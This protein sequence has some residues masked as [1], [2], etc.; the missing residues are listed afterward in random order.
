[1]NMIVF[2]SRKIFSMSNSLYTIKLT[3]DVLSFRNQ[4]FYD[5]VKQECGDII[6]EIMQLQDISS[7]DCLLDLSDIF[8]FLQQDSDELITIK[9]K[10]GIF[11]ND[12]GYVLKTGLVYKAQT[13][14]N[15]LRNL[16]RK[17]S[18]PS[19][20]QKSNKSYGLL[21]PEDI[22]QKFS[23]VRTFTVYSDLINSSKH[24]FTLLNIILNNMFRNLGTD[25]KGFRYEAVVRQ[26]ATALYILGGRNAYE[27]VRMN[28]AGLL[29]SVQVIQSFITASD[30]YLTEGDFNYTGAISYFKSVEATLGF[31]AEDATS[32]VPKISYDTKSNTFVGFSLPL[33]NFGFPIKNSYSTESFNQLEEWYSDIA[34]A[35]L[36]TAYLIQPLSSSINKLSPYLLAAYGTDNTFRSADVISR[37]HR[38]HQECKANGIRII[39]FATDC[40][41]RYLQAMRRSLGFF[42]TFVY[43][44]HP[45]LLWINLPRSWSWFFMQHEQLYICFQDPIHICTKLRNRLLSETTNLLLGNQ[46]INMEPL[47]DLID[48][49][50]KIDH[51]LVR[52]DIDPKDRQN[53]SSAAKISSDN[54]LL[55][56][57]KNTNAFGM[58]IFLQV[59]DRRFS[60]I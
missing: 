6:L 45:D 15:N 49:Y 52:S 36:L 32:V 16:N 50:S 38:I 5:L 26:F 34:R 22:L 25:E 23:F 53:Y 31:I 2:F 24:D 60:H 54:V 46:L 29:P 39:G 58:I 4:L 1:M 55:L 10:A 41:S 17:H 56:L 8:A 13:F 33:D 14:I 27:F 57:E 30:N 59:F 11:L 48:N 7:V 43:D 20:H 9:K 18:N 35:K 19:V 12:G 44:E 37:W 51:T 47:L 42:A 3:L 21:V 40:D 28:I